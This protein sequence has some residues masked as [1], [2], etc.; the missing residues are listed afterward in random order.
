ML[1]RN[2][3]FELDDSFQLSVVHVQAPSRGEGPRRKKTTNYVPRHLS[4][5]KLKKIKRSR[6]KIRRNTPGWCVALAIVTARGLYLAGSNKNARQQWTGPKRNLHWLRDTAQR[7]MAEVNLAPGAWGPTEL[8][9]VATAP[10]L[11]EYKIVVLDANRVYLPMAY[12]RGPLTIGILY[13]DNHYDALS[14][15]K[16]FLG[17]K[18]FC[19]TC[20]K[21]H[22]HQGQHR[23]PGN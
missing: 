10:S 8:E 14:S 9:R 13:D 7:L 17:K 11:S 21:G 6:I 23:C 15:I 3:N 18:H 22:D 19:S 2:E 5:V 20:L 1:N 4:K 16:G 12:G